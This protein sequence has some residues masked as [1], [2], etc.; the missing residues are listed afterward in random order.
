M[1]HATIAALM[2]SHSESLEPGVTPPL[3]I[4]QRKKPSRHNRIASSTRRSTS[5]RVPNTNSRSA[6]CIGVLTKCF[7]LI[8]AISASLGNRPL[9]SSTFR[10]APHP[11]QASTMPW[12]CRIAKSHFIA[13]DCGGIDYGRKP[14][15]KRSNAKGRR[16][17]RLVKPAALP[18]K[19][20][21]ETDQEQRPCPFA[22]GD[23]ANQK[24]G[25]RNPYQRQQRNADGI[26]PG[27]DARDQ[28]RPA[29]GFRHA[30][31]QSLDEGAIVVVLRRHQRD[32]LPAGRKDDDALTTHAFDIGAKT[33]RL[34]RYRPIR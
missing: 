18:G 4:D 27:P 30:L 32:G 17:V 23:R 33:A 29:P 1:P 15:G 9:R 8:S 11:G 13:L 12:V 5:S 31:M 14:S 7:A 34:H 10:L 6:G 28:R 2:I 25:H 19:Q 3:T 26:D 24:A 20:G 16:R 22:G 21:D